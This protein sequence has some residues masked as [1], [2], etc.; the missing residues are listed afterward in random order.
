MKKKNVTLKTGL[1]REEIQK[2]CDLYNTIDGICD[3]VAEMLDIDLSKLRKLRESS[4]ELRNMFSFKPQVGDDG[5]PNHWQP[6]VMPD[7]DKAWYPNSRQ[8]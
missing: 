3:D 7:D 4:W 8:D 2:M 5:N 1:T 6:Y